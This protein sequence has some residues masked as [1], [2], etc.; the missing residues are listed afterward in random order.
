MRQG[1]LKTAGCLALVCLLLGVGMGCAPWEGGQRVAVSTTATPTATLR[2]YV[3]PTPAP[4]P[5]IGPFPER[6]PIS[7]PSSHAVFSQLSP[8]IGAAPVWAE[9]PAGVPNRFH[10]NLPPPYPSNY[11]APYGWQAGKIVWEV[12]PR[13]AQ[14]VTVRGADLYDHTSLYLQL[15]D[16]ATPTAVTVLDPLHPGHPASALGA[17]WAEFGSYL[18][19][20]K[21]GC[22]RLEV[23]WPAGNSRPAGHWSITFA[24]GA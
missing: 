6:C 14:P 10:P 19:I 21:A 24:E 8:V 5:T 13:Y 9:W 16:A 4:T 3:T 12:G 15:G 1:L 11:L 2:P 23:S 17:S 18:V 20:P 7:P 22:Y